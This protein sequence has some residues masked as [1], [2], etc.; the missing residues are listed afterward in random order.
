MKKV[1]ESSKYLKYM[2]RIENAKNI[3]G[4]SDGDK[5]IIN[6]IIA[7]KSKLHKLVS[8]NKDNS[9]TV[10]LPIL[11]ADFFIL[12]E[13]KVDRSQSIA[14]EIVRFRK[15]Y[16]E[17][18]YRGKNSKDNR[19]PILQSY[20]DD[21]LMNVNNM[22][23]SSAKDKSQMKELIKAQTRGVETKFDY[24]LNNSNEFLTKEQHVA[25]VLTSIDNIYFFNEFSLAGINTNNPFIVCVN[26][27][28]D[29]DDA[30]ASSKMLNVKSELDHLCKRL[31]LIGIKSYIV[32]NPPRDLFIEL[33]NIF[34]PDKLHYIG[35]SE[36]THLVFRKKQ[37]ITS[38]D[39]VDA[40]E[41]NKIH[42]IFLNSCSSS[43]IAYELKQLCARQSIGYR[44]VLE[45][46]VAVMFSKEFYSLINISDF[47]QAKDIFDQAML[48][49]DA[50]SDS[51]T[52]DYVFYEQL[53][54]TV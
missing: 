14:D 3:H 8:N 27:H 52:R 33:L 19:N 48:N 25:N 36:N 29:I 54:S 53:T 13:H 49:T 38:V 15:I 21:L 47:N 5:E 44:V 50:M 30:G 40:Y 45:N 7:L 24:F 42:Y 10:Q 2:K 34:K 16:Q 41:N 37:R 1:N 31:N 43:Q 12:K 6:D 28:K 9:T 26:T 46:D 20:I 39:I 18:Y 35:H 17:K 51:K 32:I 23:M 11:L 22:I 4:I